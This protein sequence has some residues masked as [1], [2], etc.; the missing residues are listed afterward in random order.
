MWNRIGLL[1]NEAH[2]SFTSIPSAPVFTLNLFKDWSSNLNFFVVPVTSFM[3]LF[4]FS[5]LYIFVR[6][7]DGVDFQI[8]C[9]H[10][11][12]TDSAYRLRKQMMH[13]LPVICWFI[14]TNSF[15]QEVLN[16]TKTILD[17]YMTCGRS[18]WLNRLNTPK[19]TCKNIYQIIS[20]RH[21]L[22]NEQKYF[23]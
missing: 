4:Q 20:Q 1:T 22:E 7:F 11:Y 10:S 17:S 6:V 19:C 21:V 9:F 18:V 8:M 12:S 5:K 23:I 2:P 16:P 15:L 13:T 3:L 14:H